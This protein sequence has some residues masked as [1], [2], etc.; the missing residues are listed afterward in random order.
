LK[1]PSGRQGSN[2]ASSNP[3]IGEAIMPGRK[4][5]P[6]R[7]WFREDDETWL[8]LDRGRQIPQV[9]SATDIDGA[10]TALETYIARGIPPRLGGH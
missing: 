2:F 5:K 8:I 7:L 9:C 6:P 4:A 1:S 3:Q 10:A